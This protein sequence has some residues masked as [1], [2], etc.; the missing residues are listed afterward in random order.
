MENYQKHEIT[1]LDEPCQNFSVPANAEQ[2]HTIPW[3]GTGL[4]TSFCTNRI[5]AIHSK[6]ISSDALF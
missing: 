1:S 3:Q 2:Q 5:K 4:A 6:E